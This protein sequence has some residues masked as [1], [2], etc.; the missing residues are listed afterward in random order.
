[1]HPT[2]AIIYKS[3]VNLQ[4]ATNG[5][6]LSPSYWIDGIIILPIVLIVVVHFHSSGCFIMGLWEAPSFP[7]R[8]RPAIS[9]G[10][11]GAVFPKI[12]MTKIPR[13]FGHQ[14]QFLIARILKRWEKKQV[15]EIDMIYDKY[16]GNASIP[17]DDH[18]EC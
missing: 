12:S 4:K 17:Y 9:G 5:I 7:G 6:V 1:M 3:D 13:F 10:Q 11:G 14:Q 8:S 2:E 15:P 18:P 16:Q